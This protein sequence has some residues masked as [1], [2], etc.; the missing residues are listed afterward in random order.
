MN[1]ASRGGRAAKNAI[2]AVNHTSNAL[3]VK[4]L[5][6]ADYFRHAVDFLLQIPLQFIN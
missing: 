3:H 5:S 6:R 1:S 4:V 2:D